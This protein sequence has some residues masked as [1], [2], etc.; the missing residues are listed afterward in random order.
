MHR[1]ATPQRCISLSSWFDVFLDDLSLR[2]PKRRGMGTMT[3][4]SSAYESRVFFK[5]SKSHGRVGGVRMLG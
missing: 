2:G 4:Y 5:T 3:L 1:P